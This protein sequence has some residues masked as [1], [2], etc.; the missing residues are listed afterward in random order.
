[1][2]NTK[3]NV[4]SFL[5]FVSLLFSS[6]LFSGGAG[7]VPY[8]VDKGD[9]YLL[10]ATDSHRKGLGYLDFGGTQ[11]PG[12]TLAQTAAREAHEETMGVFSSTDSDPKKLRSQGI[13]FFSKRL[14]PALKVERI[15]RSNGLVYFVDVT[16]EVNRFGGRQQT[17][18]KLYSTVRRLKRKRIG[19]CFTEK[20][21]FKWFKSD[22]IE[23]IIPGQTK[24][25]IIGQHKY[26]HYRGDRFYAYF[27]HNIKQ[28]NKTFSSLVNNMNSVHLRLQKR[29]VATQNK[30]VQRRP[31]A[32]KI[33]RKTAGKRKVQKRKSPR[34]KT[35]ATR[36][37]V[38]HN[39]KKHR[40]KKRGSSRSAKKSHNKNHGSKGNRRS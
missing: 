26:Y 20:D 29:G 6:M 28:G 24:T 25:G 10:L 18:N 34:K 27:I 4:T 39:R 14:N 21:S 9:V 12:E 22:V 35:R 31:T 40:S 19:H 15:S 23:S 33:Q 16:S 11:D 38:R 13:S 30:K 7:V 5:F 32:K 37:N 36:R 17:V 1:M 3:W 2:V 8:M